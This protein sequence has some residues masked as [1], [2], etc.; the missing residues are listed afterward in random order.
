MEH[1]EDGRE[2]RG[3]RERER[4]KEFFISKKFYGRIQRD[5]VKIVEGCN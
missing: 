2:G 5:L 3:E 1:A 4:E